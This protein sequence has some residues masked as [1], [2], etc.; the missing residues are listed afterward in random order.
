LKSVGL[1][2]EQA[3]ACAV[4]PSDL[5]ITGLIRHMAEVERAWFQRWFI[6]NGASPIFYSD[7]D[8]DGDIHVGLDDTLADAIAVWEQEVQRAREITAAAQPDDVAQHVATD[9]QRA[10]F[11]PN[12]RWILNHMIEEY[13]RHCGHA[14]LLRQCIDGV[15][16]D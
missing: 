13:A 10:G 3:R 15:V 9:P 11:Q 6:E 12:M 5:N 16:G 4:P 7:D 2:D 1:T 8:P 14:D